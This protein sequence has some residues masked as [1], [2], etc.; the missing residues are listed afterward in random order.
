[1]R[2]ADAPYKLGSLATAR[3]PRWPGR[4]GGRGGTRGR[5]CRR[6]QPPIADGGNRGRPAGRTRQRPRRRRGT[7]APDPEPRLRPLHSPDAA[8]GV[9]TDRCPTPL[10]PVGRTQ[11]RSVCLRQRAPA[12]RC[13]PRE[14]Q[15]APTCP[16]RSRRR[17]RDI[18]RASPAASRRRAKADLKLRSR[19]TAAVHPPAGARLRA[20]LLHDEAWR[21]G[22]GELERAAA[23]E[24]AENASER[25]LAWCTIS[26]VYS[27][28]IGRSMFK[29]IVIYT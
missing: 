7:A 22:P 6:L 17:A 10:P 26:P 27:S 4:G 28:I 9:A 12:R 29:F 1:M 21:G 18:P 2:C 23:W 14:Q 25:L 13:R 5:A 8:R 19:W 3:R 20:A 15:P 11:A 16:P 24:R